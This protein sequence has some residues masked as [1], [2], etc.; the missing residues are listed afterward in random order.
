M[1]EVCVVKGYDEIG[2][3]DVL[4]RIGTERVITSKRLQLAHKVGALK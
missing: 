3:G 1:L 4:E 2:L